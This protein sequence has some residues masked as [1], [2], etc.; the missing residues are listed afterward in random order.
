[1]GST[2]LQIKTNSI[3]GSNDRILVFHY[4]PNMGFITGFGIKFTS[5]VMYGLSYCA[6]DLVLPVQPPDELDKI[7]TITNTSTS[8]IISCNGVELL[9]FVFS[10]SNDSKCVPQWSRKVGYLKFD[11]AGKAS[12]YYRAKPT[13]KPGVNLIP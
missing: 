2:P 12:D 7:W 6:K 1:M 13:G 8:L 9:N 4:A 10:D 11:N 5:P 3:V